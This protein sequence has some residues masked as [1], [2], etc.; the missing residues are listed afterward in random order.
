MLEDALAAPAVRA[1]PELALT[2]LAER[3][4]K[5]GNVGGVCDSSMFSATCAPPTLIK[6]SSRLAGRLAEKFSF[7]FK[8]GLAFSGFP[9]TSPTLSGDFSV[10]LSAKPW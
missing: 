9:P 3:G 2:P 5:V 4:P 10:G 7:V 8:G 1:F 6:P